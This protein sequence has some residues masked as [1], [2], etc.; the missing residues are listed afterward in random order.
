LIAVFDSYSVASNALFVKAMH[1]KAV[2]D[3]ENPC[4][5]S[6]LSARIFDKSDV[7]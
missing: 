5:D 2:W 7:H 1:A 4:F 6:S 3:N